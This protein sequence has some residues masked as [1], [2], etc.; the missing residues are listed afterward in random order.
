[1]K[2]QIQQNG[3]PL[4]VL[5]HE[6]QHWVLAPPSG[7]Y[8]I[9]LVNNSPHR[10]LAVV[11]VDGLSVLD[12][13]PASRDGNGYVLFPWQRMV[14]PGWRRNDQEV[15]RFTFTENEGSYSQAMGHGK[16][17]TG[18]IAVAVFDEKVR[19][20][21][22]I[23]VPRIVEVPVIREIPIYR[24]RVYPWDFPYLEYPE[25]HLTFTRCLALGS[26]RE[27]SHGGAACCDDSES[28]VIDASFSN[29]LDSAVVNSV[30]T[31]GVATKSTRSLDP[32][33][34]DLGTGYGSRAELRTRDIS[35]E[36]ATEAPCLELVFRYGTRERLAALGIPVDQAKS[37]EIQAPDPFPAGNCP[38]P[39]GWSG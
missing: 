33:K 7:D 8:E 15:A 2:V 17:N 16:R 25:P 5:F 11:S 21:D 36:R 20:P 6:A 31:E 12:G 1:M 28:Q 4:P 9:V 3:V 22:P 37:Q 23:F 29:H 24:R 26:N 32:S 19:V 34:V 18:V 14:I 38:A 10:R 30:H 13:K 35:F 39:P 27:S